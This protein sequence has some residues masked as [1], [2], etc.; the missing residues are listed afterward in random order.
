MPAFSLETY[1]TQALASPERFF[2]AAQSNGSL[3]AAWAEETARQAPD[4]AAAE[5]VLTVPYC[6]QPFGETPC[7]C[8]R[9]PT[10]GGKTLPASHAVPLMA[11]C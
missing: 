11:R 4:D 7:V 5:R 2:T 10:G 8:L 1:Q 6:H 3:D 9:I